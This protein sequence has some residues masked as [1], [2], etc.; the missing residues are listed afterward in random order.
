MNIIICGAG[1]VGSHTAEVLAGDGHAITVIDTDERRLARIEETMDVRTLEGSCVYGDVL[2]S[3]GGEK[4]DLLFAATESDEINLLSASV[5][6]GVGVGQTIARVRHSAYFISEQD[7][8]YG[9]LLGIDHFISPEYLTAI[10]IA[11]TLRN[12]GA[13]AIE[14]FARGRVQMQEMTVGA[15]VPAAGKALSDLGSL[16]MPAGTR[17]AAL[18]RESVSRVPEARTVIEAGDTIVLVG[19]ADVFSDARRL[20]RKESKSR[21]SVAIMGGSTMGVWLCRALKDRNFSIR[22][23][24]INRERAEELAEKLEW[25]TVLNADP[26]DPTVFADEHLA[27]ADVFVALRTEDDEH[28]ILS[29]AW[30]KSLGVKRVACTVQRPNYLHLMKHVGIDYPFAPR[31]VAV[32]EIENILSDRRLH[33]LATLAAGSVDVYQV[34]MGARSPVVGKSLREI[35]LS[36]EWVIAAIQTEEDVKVPQADDAIGVGDTVLVIGRSGEESKLKKVLGVD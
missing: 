32:K 24:E 14:N 31:T 8:D 33:Q 22:L 35:K 18:T 9:A 16:G 36:P 26:T 25:V 5:A 34:K 30:A 4:A 15:G 28:N 1:T 11:A 7:M 17:V 27:D 20:F 12:P 23:F 3:A 29:C 6:K 2:R 13:L 19:N 21:R 10:T